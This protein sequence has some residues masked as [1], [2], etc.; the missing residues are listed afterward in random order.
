MTAT[1]LVGSYSLAMPCSAKARFAQLYKAS[2]V[3]ESSLMRVDFA[4]STTFANASCFFRERSGA[5]RSEAVVSVMM[6]R[7]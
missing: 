1:L 6:S 5:E 7:K 2:G 3:R 4:I